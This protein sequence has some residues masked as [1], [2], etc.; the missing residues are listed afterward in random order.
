MQT[1]VKIPISKLK[2]GMYI[3]EDVISENG[4]LLFCADT[5][6][7]NPTQIQRL[8]NQGVRDVSINVNK[9]ANQLNQPKNQK[10]TAHSKSLYSGPLICFKHDIYQAQAVI[11]KSILL[12]KKCMDSLLK[13][14]NLSV[15]GVNCIAQTIVEEVIARRDALL[16]VC[17]MQ[18]KDDPLYAHS[19]SVCATS[20][21]LAYS[22]NLSRNDIVKCATGAILHDIGMLEISQN[23]L[24]KNVNLTK[25]EYSELQKHPG[26]G[27][28]IIEKTGR[29]PEIVKT[30]V[31]Q[32]HERWNGGGYPNRLKKDAIEHF[33]MICS[34][35]DIYDSLTRNSEH[36]RACL[37]QEAMAL[38]FQGANQDYPRYI[39]EAFTRLMGIYPVGSFVKL[40]T[41]EIGLVVKNRPKSLMTPSTIICFNPRDGKLK[42]PFYR[43][44]YPVSSTAVQQLWK[45]ESTVEPQKLGMSIHSVISSATQN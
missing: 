23:I 19:V 39:V 33:S 18:I 41:G 32:H 35:S 30:I 9:N 42:R 4:I 7:T 45:I 16:L 25:T 6:I 21:A 28:G 27:A 40:T 36:K 44:L 43:D 2:L 17:R 38:I 24:K 12:F 29:F 15:E 31:M 34:V 10:T 22:L 3:Q 11:Y 13:D 1:T 37:P 5:F 20:A 8:K 14:I 26:L